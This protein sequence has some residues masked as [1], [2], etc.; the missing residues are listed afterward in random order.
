MTNPIT[1]VVVS[2]QVAPTPSTLQKTGA[3]ISQGGTTLAVDSIKFL[4]QPSD[5]TSILQGAIPLSG[6]T[7]SGGV[8]TATLESST[9]SSGT[10]NST[11]GLVTLTLAATVGAE[12]GSLVTV[13]SATGTGAYADIDGTWPCAAGTSG[14][15]V[16]FYIAAALTMTITG[17]NIESTTGLANGTTFLT[18]IAGASPA[19]YNGTFLATV[20][21]ATTFTYAVPSGTATPATGSPTYT[22]SGVSATLEAVTT[23]FDQGSGQGVYILELG[24]GTAAAGVT[25]LSSYITANPGVF[26]SYTVPKSWDGVSS[27]LTFLAGFELT[28]S[29]TYFFVTTSTTNYTDYT[30]MKCV[31]AN[32]EAPG[33]APGTEHDSAGVQQITLNY[34]PSS[35]NLVTPLNLSYVFGMTPYPTAGNAS[36]LTTLNTASVNVIGTGAQG[37]ISE[38]ILIGGNTMD[39]NPFNYW[40]SVDWAQINGS[41]A[42]TNALING[43]NNP[44]NPVYYNQNGINTLQQALV[45]VMTN[46]IA[47]GLVLNPVKATQL[48]A[49][50]F[51][52]ALAAGVFDGFTVVNADPFSSYTN[53]NPNDYAAGRYNGLSVY[54]VPLRGFESIQ[55]SITV[56]NFAS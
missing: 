1:S 9:I 34:A 51:A 27:F 53:E 49:S 18:T 17:G 4:T 6:I 23:F 31:L 13:A 45:T 55:F 14:T 36:L 44:T 50:A 11:T 16:T 2:Q 52:A 33:L 39:G 47:Y 26:Y 38:D 8:A 30:G 21:S 48:S 24:A 19:A 37:G 56:S 54:Y 5:L 12:P 20:A 32:V 46:G 3:I 29:K 41:L 28:T 42:V 25:A 22:P 35:T 15:T 7:Q 43:S 10:Y 40:Y